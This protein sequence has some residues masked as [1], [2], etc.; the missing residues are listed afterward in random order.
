MVKSFKPLHND[1][2]VH[3]PAD[4]SRLRPLQTLAPRE[5]FVRLGTAEESALLEAARREDALAA[6]GQRIKGLAAPDLAVAD[7][8][9]IH[10]DRLRA[11][12]AAFRR[13]RSCAATFSHPVPPA[14]EALVH[15]LL[16]TALGGSVAQLRWTDLDERAMTVTL[17]GYMYRPQR[18]LAITPELLV[19]LQRLPRTS[20]RIFDFGGS[21]ITSAWRNFCRRPELTLL[22]IGHSRLRREAVYR[23]SERFPTE[24]E[25]RAFL[26]HMPR[27]SRRFLW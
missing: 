24:C 26:G 11:R 6:Q 25:L 8:Q 16:Q 21:G 18:V 10:S 13:A 22:E 15:M 23:A 9:A 12:R 1:I 14:Y 20:T 3:V 2:R 19:L 27:S 7:M 17:D 5:P 4:F